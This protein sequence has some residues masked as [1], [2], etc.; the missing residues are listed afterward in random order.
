M[1][2]LSLLVALLTMPAA[3]AAQG[4]PV[5]FDPEPDA[6][7]Q[8]AQVDAATPAAEALPPKPRSVRY[9][10]PKI[11]YPNAPTAPIL[12]AARAGGAN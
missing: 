5:D 8:S 6:A 10:Q 11:R 3:L 12:I 7:S 9:S 1:M 4:L 2:R